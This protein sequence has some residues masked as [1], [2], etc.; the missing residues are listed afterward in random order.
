MI[1]KDD[2]STSILLILLFSASQFIISCGGGANEEALSSIE[3]PQNTQ[4]IIMFTTGDVQ[5][6]QNNEWSDAEINDFLEKGDT[7]KVETDSFCEIQF[8]SRAVVKI[9]ENTEL[10]IPTLQ[11]GNEGAAINIKMLTGSVLSKV[12]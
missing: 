8:G 10:V 2:L 7:V 6:L 9:E 1:K 5:K 12:N 3:L 11:A 4:G